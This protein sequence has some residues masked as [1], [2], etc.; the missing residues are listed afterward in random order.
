MR[1]CLGVVCVGARLQ[2][3]AGSLGLV[4]TRLPAAQLARLSAVYILVVQ[5][6]VIKL[7]WCTCAGVPAG[8]VL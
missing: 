5:F 6:C 2:E 8:G 7:S 1:Q 4:P 3:G